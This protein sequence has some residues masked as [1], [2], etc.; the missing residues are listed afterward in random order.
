M[1]STRAYALSGQGL[2]RML[3]ESPRDTPEY[4]PIVTTVLDVQRDGV[5]E[6][7]LY[8]DVVIL[9]T[10]PLPAA[11]YDTTISW[12]PARDR[13]ACIHH[14]DAYCDDLTVPPAPFPT[15]RAADIAI[16][17][18]GGFLK[19]SVNVPPLAGDPVN[20]VEL[21]NNHAAGGGAAA[22]TCLKPALHSSWLA[23][24]RAAATRLYWD[25]RL[26]V[27]GSAFDAAI[28]P[29]VDRAGTLLVHYGRT[30]LAAE[31]DTLVLCVHYTLAPYGTYPIR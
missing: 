1:E 3:G 26:Y 27:N 30:A 8:C 12:S 18:V 15:Y 24:Q 21:R 7:R 28:G 2:R 22:F 4:L 10:P 19:G 6:Q 29:V 5:A 23:E 25:G 9:E 16:G 14:V 13:V 17:L 11:R 20:E 31:T